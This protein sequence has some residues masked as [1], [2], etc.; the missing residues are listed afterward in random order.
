[1]D[2]FHPFLPL[3]PHHPTQTGDSWAG[4]LKS[5]FLSVQSKTAPLPPLIVANS[6]TSLAS[7]RTTETSSQ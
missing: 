1:M 5:D 2:G 3:N 7:K 6:G 4:G